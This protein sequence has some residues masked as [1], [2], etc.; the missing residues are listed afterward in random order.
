[1]QTNMLCIVQ[2]L[3]LY[4]PYLFDSLTGWQEYTEPLETPTAYRSI[5]TIADEPQDTFLD[6]SSWNKG[7]VFVNGFNLGRYW[8]VG[9]THT[10]YI[11]APLLIQGDN[12]VSLQ[13]S[14]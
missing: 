4:L 10:L 2:C 14:L 6:M 5:V 1:M 7:V 13:I 3:S 8:T 9:P 11:P 12:E